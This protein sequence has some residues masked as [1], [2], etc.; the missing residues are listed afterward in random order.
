MIPPNSNASL[1]GNATFIQAV[2]LN[3]DGTTDLLVYDAQNTS[4]SAFNGD[5]IGGFQR[6]DIS[7]AAPGT[8]LL[9]GDFGGNSL[10]GGIALPQLALIR[11]NTSQIQ[12]MQNRGDFL[13]Q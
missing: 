10:D 2:D 7:L 5:G 13:F 4:A 11:V 9:A 6:I 1:T 3:G 12:L 8:A